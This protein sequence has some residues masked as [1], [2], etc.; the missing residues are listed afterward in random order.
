MGNQNTRRST[1]VLPSN[2]A[3]RRQCA[4]PFFLRKGAQRGHTLLRSAFATLSRFGTPVSCVSARVHRWAKWI[5]SVMLGT[6]GHAQGCALC[7][8]APCRIDDQFVVLSRTVR[9]CPASK[10]SFDK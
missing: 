7:M 4:Q 3:E 2:S 1:A 8:H 10:V 5:H 9:G 6:I